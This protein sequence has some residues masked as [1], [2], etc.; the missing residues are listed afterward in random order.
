MSKEGLYQVYTK[1]LQDI[2]AE[3]EKEQIIKKRKKYLRDV[4]DFESQ[5]VFKWQEL[6]N[7]NPVQ[8]SEMVSMESDESVKYTDV[9]SIY[10]L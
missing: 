10:Q 3:E 7:K 1:E 8:A 5:N 6:Y 4:E 9:A 2:M